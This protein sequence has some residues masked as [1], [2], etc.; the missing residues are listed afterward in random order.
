MD[1]NKIIKERFNPDEEYLGADKEVNRIE[2]LVS[3]YIPA[4]Q[5]KDFI[6][7]CIESV[8]SQKTTF[9]YEVLIGED[10][11]TDGTREI[12]IR[13]AEK[14]PDK[15]RLFLRNRKTSVLRNHEGNVVTY[16]NVKFLRMSCRGH[17]YAVCEGDDYWIDDLKLEKQ[18]KLMNQYPQCGM[19]YHPVIL[20]IYSSG[21][22]MIANRH[23]DQTCVSRTER[24]VLG[25]GAYCPT[26]SLMFRKEVFDNDISWMHTFPVG[27]YFIQ[28]YASL[29]GGALYIDEVMGTY[30]KGVPGSWTDRTR[31]NEAKFR[32]IIR[33]IHSMK[34]FNEKTDFRLNGELKQRENMEIFQ[35]LK[36]VYAYKREEIDLIK[37]IIRSETEG[38][39][40]LK[41]NYHLL[42]SFLY[43]KFNL[44]YVTKMLMRYHLR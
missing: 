24:I 6:A 31:S 36:N 10:E 2:P 35:S 7:E 11:S 22:T 18:V 32:H 42:K 3:V 12:C 1:F 14:Y 40:R 44:K 41:F 21:S 37:L 23:Y 43:H 15:I 17:F 25:G 30:R 8:I 26:C 16:L 19:S 29:C 34:V 5:H 38:I 28:M 9:S 39:L 13:Y 4:Y 20:H 33:M 27:D